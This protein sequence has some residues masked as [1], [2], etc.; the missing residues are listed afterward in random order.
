VSLIV[1]VN[2]GLKLLFHECPGMGTDFSYRSM[3]VQEEIR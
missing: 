3:V 2:E 1:K